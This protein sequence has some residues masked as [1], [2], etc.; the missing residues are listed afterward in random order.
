MNSATLPSEELEQIA[1]ACIDF[2]ASDPEML[3]RFMADA[4]IGPDALRRGLSDGSLT[5][6]LIHHFAH[7]ESALVA[8]CANKGL[9][10][11]RVMRAYYS[12]NPDG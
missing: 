1:G 10:P 12:L 9:T 2:L 7:D 5:P 3:A 8:M 6:G 11:E 4:G